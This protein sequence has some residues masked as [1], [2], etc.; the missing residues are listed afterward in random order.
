MQHGLAGIGGELC[1]EHHAPERWPWLADRAAEAG[2]AFVRMANS[3]GTSS[4]RPTIA[5]SLP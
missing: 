5:S 4:S 1:F 3:S 2:L